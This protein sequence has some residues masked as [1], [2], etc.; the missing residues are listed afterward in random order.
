MFIEQ[1]CGYFDN[2]EENKLVYTELHERFKDM[3]DSL[4]DNLV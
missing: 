4:F 2:E 1:N 3:V